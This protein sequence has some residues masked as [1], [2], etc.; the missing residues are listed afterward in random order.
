MER[1][2]NGLWRMYLL[3]PIGKQDLQWH[4][5]LPQ[6]VFNWFTIRI[7][8]S[9]AMWLAD[10]I[11]QALFMYTNIFGR[12]Q[13]ITK[14]IVLFFFFFMQLTRC[15][16]TFRRVQTYKLNKTI[17]LPKRVSKCPKRQLDTF[18]VQIKDV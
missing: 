2:L 17:N 4:K 9:L 13:N 7:T 10:G 5:R 18:H 16:K 1:F 15:R 12:T 8:P 3:C 14:I 11:L 6:W